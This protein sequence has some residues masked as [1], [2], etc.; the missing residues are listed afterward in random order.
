MKIDYYSPSIVNGL[1][2]DNS[3]VANKNDKGSISTS[4]NENIAVL[5]NRSPFRANISDEAIKNFSNDMMKLKLS[6]KNN[7]ES[8]S[9]SVLLDEFLAKYDKY[10]E[11]G[12]IADE[13]DDNVANKPLQNTILDL[14][15][16]FRVKA[17]NEMCQINLREGLSRAKMAI[18]LARALDIHHIDGSDRGIANMMELY[19][20]KL[21]EGTLKS[22]NTEILNMSD[23]DEY[24]EK[25]YKDKE[26]ATKDYDTYK[27][28]LQKLDE[29]KNLFL[30]DFKEKYK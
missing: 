26:A 13:V 19:R 3:G 10:K 12:L 14:V 22:A 30:Q 24:C 1:K 17:A 18:F 2:V 4:I 20:K 23:F 21:K 7:S 15:G 11:Q 25:Y 16:E 29:I 6:L 8:N 5:Y 9:D 28:V 27:S